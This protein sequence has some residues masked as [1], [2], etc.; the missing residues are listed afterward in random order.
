[1]RL[2]AVQTP[3]RAH[4]PWV[5]RCRPVEVRREVRWEHLPAMQD[6][7]PVEHK[8]GHLM[9]CRHGKASSMPA[10]DVCHVLP[11]GGPAT[12]CR[13]QSVRWCL[14]SSAPPSAVHGPAMSGS[15]P[16]SP[17]RPAVVLWAMRWAH[18]AQH[19]QAH[20]RRRR[21]RC[22]EARRWERL[23]APPRHRLSSTS[24]HREQASAGQQEPSWSRHGASARAG[25]LCTTQALPMAEEQGQSPSKAA[26]LTDVA[27]SG[28]ALY[29]PRAALSAKEGLLSGEPSRAHPASTSGMVQGRAVTSLMG[30][31]TGTPKPALALACRT[32]APM[33]CGAGGARTRSGHP[34]A[35]YGVRNSQRR[36]P[37]RPRPPGACLRTCLHGMDA[38]SSGTVRA[39]LRAS[40]TPP[41]ACPAPLPSGRMLG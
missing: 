5:P 7:E 16:A 12:G 38:L 25:Q 30:T 13:W 31:V 20:L 21:S 37:C 26:S 41:W 40:G 10:G 4:R 39:S 3:L 18:L 35:G 32:A 2:G 22:R 9:L 28:L 6:A 23:D 29:W 8:A 15:L 11:M 34:K 24:R 36:L 14:D 19:L 17:S 33:L 27:S 1:M